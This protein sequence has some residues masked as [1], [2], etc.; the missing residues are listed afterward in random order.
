MQ[1]LMPQQDKPKDYVISGK[2]YLCVNSFVD[3]S[4]TG[5]EIEFIGSGLDEVGVVVGHQEIKPVH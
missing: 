4:G 1:W 5:I 3:S 2:Q